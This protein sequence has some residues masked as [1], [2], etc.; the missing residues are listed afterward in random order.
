[1]WTGFWSN[2][3]EEG[4][5]ESSFQDEEGGMVYLQAL[6]YK[7]ISSISSNQIG[8]INFHHSFGEKGG[9]LSADFDLGHF[10][11]DYSNSLLTE[12]VVV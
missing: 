8:N 2:F 7:T 5:A 6:T 12:T 10:T 3:G 9:E 1:M 4:T 11:R